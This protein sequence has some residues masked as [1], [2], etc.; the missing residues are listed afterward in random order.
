[1]QP[2]PNLDDSADAM[3]LA[4]TLAGLVPAL[5]VGLVVLLLVDP[6]PA[7]VAVVLVVGAWVLLVRSRA[8]TAPQR[9]LSGLESTELRP[10]AEPRLENLLESVCV[11]SGIEQPAVRVLPDATCNAL[12]VAGSGEATFVV[13]RGLLDELGRIELEAVLANL[14]ARVKSGGARFATTALALPVPAAYTERVLRDAFGDQA[15]VR[16]D[17][18]A[19]GLTKYPPGLIAAFGVM[20]ARGTAVRSA[21]TVG[22]PLWVADPSS[23]GSAQAG[24]GDALSPQ[25]LPLR[26]AVL[27]AL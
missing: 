11:V 8:A 20:D 23:E 17:L 6:L 4:V 12:A 9:A 13:T 1:M 2:S 5:L 25:P 7:L 14:A 22:A 10:G 16:S 19:V 27:E 21:S 18:D 15:S 3:V 26:I 24:A